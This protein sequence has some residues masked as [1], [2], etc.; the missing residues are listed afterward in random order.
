VRLLLRILRH[1]DER[2]VVAYSVDTGELLAIARA[3]LSRSDEA[4][5]DVQLDEELR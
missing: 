1:Y 5:P 4:E 3:E 2:P